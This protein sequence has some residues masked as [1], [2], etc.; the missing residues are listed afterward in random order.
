[1]QSDLRL[2]KLYESCLPAWAEFLQSYGLPYH[3][4][5]LVHQIMTFHTSLAL[6]CMHAERTAHP[7]S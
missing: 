2:L 4:L 3:Q 1:M 7:V 5:N 6:P